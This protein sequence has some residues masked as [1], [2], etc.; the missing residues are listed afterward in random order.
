MIFGSPKANNLLH[1]TV[2]RR[3]LQTA[4]LML[5]LLTLSMVPSLRWV[6]G[7]NPTC[8]LLS[9]LRS[10]RAK[11]MHGEVDVEDNVWI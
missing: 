2:L 10:L 7:A 9:M 5:L 8:W 11:G 3:M 4:L 1:S 6:R